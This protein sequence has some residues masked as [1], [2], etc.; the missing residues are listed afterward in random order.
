MRI[1]GYPTTLVVNDDPFQSRLATSLLEKDGLRVLSGQNVKGALQT[2]DKQRPVS[3]IV[4][5]LHLMDI[6]G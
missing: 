3:V 5:N 1:A 4:T 6:D 2:L